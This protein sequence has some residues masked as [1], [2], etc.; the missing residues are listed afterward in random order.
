MD[1]HKNSYNDDVEL[2]V[3]YTKNIPECGVSP[4]AEKLGC[5]CVAGK[6]ASVVGV[7]CT[8]TEGITPLSVPC[9]ST[10]ASNTTGY[11]FD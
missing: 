2:T 1:L 6:V 7:C 11:I 3:D 9:V 10:K 8:E 5:C 4:D